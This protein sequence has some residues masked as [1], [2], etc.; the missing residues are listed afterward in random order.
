MLLRRVRPGTAY[1][2]AAG[3]A[4]GGA[5]WW[6]RSVTQVDVGRGLTAASCEWPP[7]MVL[8]DSGVQGAAWPLHAVVGWWVWCVPQAAGWA[9]RGVGWCYISGMGVE[10]GRLVIAAVCGLPPG[11]VLASQLGA[12]GQR[13]PK[14]RPGHCIIPGQGAA[15]PLHTTRPRCGLATA[16]SSSHGHLAVLHLL[17]LVL[18]RRVGSA[19]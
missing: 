12:G 6:Y 1:L 2:K 17:P 3:Y 19:A 10:V 18:L 16:C 5:G 9:V 7:G 4:A 14:V 8:E 13:G 15:W 11:L